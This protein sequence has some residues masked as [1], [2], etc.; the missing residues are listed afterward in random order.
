[1]M[2]YIVVLIITVISIIID[3]KNDWGIFK[4]NK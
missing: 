4:N 3:Y 2:E 1:M